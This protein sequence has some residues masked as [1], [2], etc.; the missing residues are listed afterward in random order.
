MAITLGDAILYI[1]SESSGL[2]RGLRSAETKTQSWVTRTGNAIKTALGAAVLLLTWDKFRMLPPL[3]KQHHLN[4]HSPHL[5][6]LPRS[7]FHV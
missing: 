7:I 1:K 5:G 6:Q 3:S 4:C 2:D